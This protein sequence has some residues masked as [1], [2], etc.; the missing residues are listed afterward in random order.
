M[1]V[2][3]RPPNEVLENPPKTV[4]DIV[5]V[6]H[7]V[8]I[9]C[10]VEAK[11]GEGQFTE[12]VGVKYPKKGFPFPEAIYAINQ[13]KRNTMMLL[14]SLVRKELILSY[15]G[16]ALI[17]FKK[18][19][20][21]IENIL[22]QYNRNNDYLLQNVYV[23]Y[24]YMT[25]CARALRSF[26]ED[27]LIGIGI[28]KETSQ[29]TAKIFS[30]MVEYD[31]AYRYRIQDIFSVVT[32]EEFYSHPSQAIELMVDTI[33]KRDLNQHN[34]VPRFKAI[35]RLMRF[36]LLHPRVRS[37]FYSTSEWL[38]FKNLQMDEADRYHCLIRIDYNFEGRPY[39]ERLKEYLEI[40][41]DGLPPVI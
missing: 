34:V 4:N 21:F 23:K 27:F 22:E 41:K 16:F 10:G 29:L 3:Y 13:V 12:F 5:G 25:P 30:H 19:I 11:K 6:D 15:I 31:D 8:H 28:K 39:E 24:E 7:R 17:R 9:L 37:A 38:V 35:G 40:H 32:E 20:S 18:K 36:S 2:I 26:I 33:A 1:T 14:L